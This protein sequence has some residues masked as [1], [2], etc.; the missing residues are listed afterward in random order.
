VSAS[1]V[2]ARLSRQPQRGQRSSSQ[3]ALL[4]GLR[5]GSSTSVLPRIRSNHKRPTKST[6]ARGGGSRRV[7]FPDGNVEGSAKSRTW[8]HERA[9]HR[10]RFDLQA[11]PS[12]PAP[13]PQGERGESSRVDGRSTTRVAR[14]SS[15]LS[16]CGRGAA[17]EGDCPLSACQKPRRDLKLNR[18]E[19]FGQLGLRKNFPGRS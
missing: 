15:P 3:N 2:C 6:R 4:I 8:L 14:K 11:S 10:V 9:R 12:P 19:I 5:T 17:G 7:L 1:E 16:P 13:L 18:H